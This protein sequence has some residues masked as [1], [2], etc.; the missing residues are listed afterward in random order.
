MPTPLEDIEARLAAL[1][2]AVES[3]RGK[4][5]RAAGEACPRCGEFE[6]RTET[7]KPMSGHLGKLGAQ[8]R[9]LKCAACSYSEPRTETP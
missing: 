7:V 1:E 3:M 2:S 6:F 5:L 4:P 8:I 9:T